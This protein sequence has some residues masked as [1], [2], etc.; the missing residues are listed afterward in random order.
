[1][2]ASKRIQ[3]GSDTPSD[4]LSG[5]CSDIKVVRELR[6]AIDEVHGCNSDRNGDVEA[7]FVN[8]E[9]RTDCT[10]SWQDARHERDKQEK[11]EVHLVQ[12]GRIVEL[13][14]WVCWLEGFFGMR[15]RSVMGGK[16][17]GLK[18]LRTCGEKFC[19]LGAAPSPSITEERSAEIGVIEE[20]VPFS[21]AGRG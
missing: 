18:G 5:E 4:E 20:V 3:S 17:N 15:V 14:I 1:L 13:C 9:R 12:I 7:E 16:R 2:C 19:E 10:S 6:G 11:K 21:E 8:S